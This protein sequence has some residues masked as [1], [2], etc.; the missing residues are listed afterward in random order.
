MIQFTIDGGAVETAT[1]Q[2][3]PVQWRTAQHVAHQAVMTA[4]SEL[5][6]EEIRPASREHWQKM[7]AAFERRAAAWRQLAA[8]TDRDAF[9][10][11]ARAMELAAPGDVLR[12]GMLRSRLGATG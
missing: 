7:A 5:A 4:E 6:V 11:G 12:A 10:H 9:G 8:T 3:A 2:V 1:T